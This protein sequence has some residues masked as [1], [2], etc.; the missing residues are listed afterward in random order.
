MA[1]WSAKPRRPSATLA[2]DGFALTPGANIQNL[3]TYDRARDELH[4]PTT[5]AYEDLR[6]IAPPFYDPPWDLYLSPVRAINYSPT[7][8]CYWNRCAF[9]S[10]GLTEGRSTAPWRVRPAGLVA[11][12]LA[13][14]CRRQ[15]V[16]YVYFAV[17]AISPTYLREL[18]DALLR[19][20]T[21]FKWS[22]EMRMERALR[23]ELSAKL[24]RSGCVSA[25]FGLESGCQRV[26]D[27]MDKGTSVEQMATSMERL[28]DAGIAVQL[29]TFSGFPSETLEDR[30][31]TLRFLERCSNHWSNGGMGSFVLLAGSTVARDPE[32]FGV[33]LKPME[34]CDIAAILAFEY[35]DA[36]P[37]AEFSGEDDALTT[38]AKALFPVSFPR[39]WAGSADTLHSMVYYH[40]LGRRFFRDHPLPEEP[41]APVP[42]DDTALGLCSIRLHGRMSESCFDLGSLLTE[43]E[44]WRSDTP[45]LSETG[46][47]RLRPALP[48]PSPRRLAFLAASGTITC[49]EPGGASRSRSARTHLSAA[50]SR[51]ALPV[52]EACAPLPPE[53]GQTLISYLRKLGHLRVVEFVPSG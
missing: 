10:Y 1:S 16:G 43:R 7:R 22:A 4:L 17:D 50:S 14:T 15:D 25:L 24:A 28:A 37:R 26:L 51:E 40:R 35:V 6:S 45:F 41:S 2:D 5:I 19:E 30:A 21:T 36:D 12:E 53:A 27:A 44:Q 11:R 52:G 39:P 48:Q 46:G 34:D 3:V 9:C 47:P 29:M 32:R 18:S 42:T 23:P 13:D 49:R 8:G 31:E 38:W 20:E 33:R